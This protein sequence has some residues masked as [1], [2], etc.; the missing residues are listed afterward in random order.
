MQG[1]SHFEVSTRAA[2]GRPTGAKRA[3]QRVPPTAAPAKGATRDVGQRW[4]KAVTWKVL[5]WLSIVQD[6]PPRL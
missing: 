3:P 5:P 2:P 1:L 6:E 4:K